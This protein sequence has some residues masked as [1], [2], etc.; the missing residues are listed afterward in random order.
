MTLPTGNVLAL[1][2]VPTQHTK[3]PLRYPVH[4]DI[5]GPCDA[6]GQRD[7]PMSVFSLISDKPDATPSAP[8]VLSPWEHFESSAVSCRGPTCL[9]S[10]GNPRT[11][12]TIATDENRLQFSLT[13][14]GSQAER[15]TFN[16]AQLQR[17]LLTPQRYRTLSLRDWVHGMDTTVGSLCEPS[18]VYCIGGLRTC[19][20]HTLPTEPST[21]EDEEHYHEYDVHYHKYDGRY[22]DFA[23]VSTLHVSS[24]TTTRSRLASPLASRHPRGSNDKHETPVTKA[25]FRHAM[26]DVNIVARRPQGCRELEA[27]IPPNDYVVVYAGSEHLVAISEESREVMYSRSASIHVWAF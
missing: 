23:G 25:R 18:D 13:T 7:E 3:E 15:Y 21:D 4:A 11:A 12:P 2:L 16:A 1:G 27:K 8:N 6:R 9:V 19:R 5:D 26:K 24:S 10:H 22:H 14:A 17:L 20:I